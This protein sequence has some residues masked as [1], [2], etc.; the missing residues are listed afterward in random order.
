MMQYEAL[1][2]S[3]MKP[4]EDS[5]VHYVVMNVYLTEIKKPDGT[6]ILGPEI[7]ATSLENANIHIKS[8]SHYPYIEVIGKKPKDNHYT[9]IEVKGNSLTLYNSTDESVTDEI[10]KIKNGSSIIDTSKPPVFT[11]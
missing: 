2:N 5:S 3:K 4:K 9:H 8:S 1:K 7:K 6:Y 10:E 11:L